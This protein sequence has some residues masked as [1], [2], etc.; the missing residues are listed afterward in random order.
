MD[1]GILRDT[2]RVSLAIKALRREDH[3]LARGLQ[4]TLQSL[5]TCVRQAQIYIMG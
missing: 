5:H 4:R 1:F 3:D 2:F